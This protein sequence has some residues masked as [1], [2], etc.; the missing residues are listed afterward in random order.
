MWTLN[1]LRKLIG[2]VFLTAGMAMALAVPALGGEFDLSLNG[3]TL[4]WRLDPPDGGAPSYMVGTIHMVDDRLG[5]AIDRAMRRLDETGAL[6]VETDVSELAQLNV[7]QAMM[8]QGDRSLPDIVGEDVFDRLL[9]VAEP[10]G[11]PAYFLRKLAP[12]GAAM[13]ISVPADQ[14]RAM[15]A[16]GAVFDQ[17]LVNAAEAR[18]MPVETLEAIDEQVAVFADHPEADQVSL[19]VAALEMHP[20]LDAMV[21]EMVGR[22]VADDLAGLAEVAM[23]EM[24]MGDEELSERMINALIVDRNRRMAERVAPLLQSRPHLVAIGAMHLPGEVG[25]LN[26]LAQRGWTVAPA[27]E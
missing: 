3:D 10:Y 2:R 27:P 8:L 21:A 12:W 17:L 26:L 11:M 18:A 13:M 24:D 4:M 19:L 7:M 1:P 23:R 16:G 25:V 20:K 14:V 9:A 22:Y 6:V 5:P 15:A